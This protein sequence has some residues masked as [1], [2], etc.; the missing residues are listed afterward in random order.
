MTTEIENA[1]TETLQII[2]NYIDVAIVNNHETVTSNT[3]TI[4]ELR[5]KYRLSVARV[6]I[7]LKQTAEYVN[8][9]ENGLRRVTV[10]DAIKLAA[11]Y[12]VSAD[13]LI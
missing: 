12:N 9:L 11:L 2:K 10:D 3:K 4:V 13:S 6:A 7:E 8:Q 1:I 5:K